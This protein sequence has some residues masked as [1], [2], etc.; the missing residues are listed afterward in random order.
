[1]K[2][3]HTSNAI[4]LIFE[5]LLITDKE[6]KAIYEDSENKFK[7]YIL[8]CSFTEEFCLNIK[9]DLAKEGFTINFGPYKDDP[10]YNLLTIENCKDKILFLKQDFVNSI[11]KLLKINLSTLLAF[12]AVISTFCFL[13]GSMVV[14][15]QIKDLGLDQWASD[16]FSQINIHLLT[17]GT[18]IF[19]SFFLFILMAGVFLNFVLMEFYKQG[20][21]SK[22]FYKLAPKLQFI[23]LLLYGT[24]YSLPISLHSIFW[25]I[26]VIFTANS[27]ITSMIFIGN[28]FFSIS[29]L[30]KIPNLIEI[31]YL[32][33]CTKL[34]VFFTYTFAASYFFYG[35]HMYNKSGYDQAITF[36][37]FSIVFYMT[38]HFQFFI[39]RQKAKRYKHLSFFGFVSF[40]LIYIIA[41][42]LFFKNVNLLNTM[43]LG[44]YQG[45]FILDNS[46]NQAFRKAIIVNNQKLNS[47]LLNE[48][49]LSLRKAFNYNYYQDPDSIQPWVALNVGNILI[50][51]CDSEENYLFVFDKNP[52]RFEGLRK[53]NL[54]L[55]LSQCQ[56]DVAKI[57]NATGQSNPS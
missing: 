9:P 7:T 4:K 51:S 8:D 29:A 3:I 38:I 46:F 53:R 56:Q 33:I 28:R 37:C 57:L 10:R 43:G 32:L 12:M 42:S 6:I 52:Y 55:K 1:M 27:L 16:I 39:S 24:I 47:T 30:K 34:L 19:F 18:G 26:I 25:A 36:I 31:S 2:S 11:F 15:I 45:Q 23:E 50:I 44:D 14:Y 35:F 41:V 20:Q 40:I 5:K 49:A 21:D 13:A 22:F 54:T 17:F 48:E